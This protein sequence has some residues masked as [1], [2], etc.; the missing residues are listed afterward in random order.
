MLRKFLSVKAAYIE[1]MSG[2]IIMG[3]GQEPAA[4]C[5]AGLAVI[6]ILSFFRGKNYRSKLVQ[7]MS[8]SKPYKQY[9]CYGNDYGNSWLTKDVQAVEKYYN[10][11]Y[12]TFMFT[13]NAYKGLY[14]N[15]AFSQRQK[16]Y[17]AKSTEKKKKL[18]NNLKLLK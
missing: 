3:T 1:A 16:I 5:T 17:K 4:T 9:D 2:A 7:N 8:Y 10:D 15:K 12:C 13:V 18:E 6:S 14:N 11:P